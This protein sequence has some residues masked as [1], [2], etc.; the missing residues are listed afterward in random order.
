MSDSSAV[1]LPQ[2]DQYYPSNDPTKPICRHFVNKGKCNRKKRCRFY[3]PSNITPNIKKQARRDIGHCY[4]GATQ[5]CVI[6]KRSYSLSENIDTPLFFVVCSRT[7]RS[8]KRCM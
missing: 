3:H 8:M 2:S 1:S 4:C 7:G 6:N 5:K